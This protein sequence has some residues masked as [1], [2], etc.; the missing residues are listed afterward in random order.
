[1]DREE[2]DPN[3]Q[4]E[5]D[6]LILDYLLCTAIELLICHG[7]ARIE[8]QRQD[9]QDIDWYISTVETIRTVLLDPDILS[10]DICTKDR[11]LKFTVTFCQRYDFLQ[12]RDPEATAMTLLVNFLALCEGAESLPALR[13]AIFAH[14]IMEAASEELAATDSQ[15]IPE[16]DECIHRVHEAIGQTLQSKGKRDYLKYFQPS[17]DLPLEVHIQSM[18]NKLPT[19]QLVSAVFDFLID[20][21]KS[22]NPPVL[23]QL[24]RGKLDGLTREE[25]RRLKD[26]IGI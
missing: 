21:M 13:D 8:G 20:L 22:L 9:Y 12:N 6:V 10:N 3:T 1:M 11:L 17:C 24:E 7:R 26:K 25:T 5:V 2:A 18:S 14:L 16:Y 19:A 4:R 15:P 23:L